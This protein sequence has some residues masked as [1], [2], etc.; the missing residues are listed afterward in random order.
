MTSCHRDFSGHGD[1][2]VPGWKPSRTTTT[3]VA[4]CCSRA[5]SLFSARWWTRSRIQ[6]SRTNS[7]SSQMSESRASSTRGR[8]GLARGRLIHRAL[9]ATRDGQLR[10]Q[11]S[12]P[13]PPLSLPLSL[14]KRCATFLSFLL[15]IQDPTPVA[16]PAAPALSVL[17]PRRSFSLC[18]R[19]TP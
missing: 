1:A 15:Y 19:L 8:D 4:Y 7:T 3:T 18:D 5:L 11:D 12:A 17:F 14:F 6:Q 13:H 2:R 10:R 16:P 9:A